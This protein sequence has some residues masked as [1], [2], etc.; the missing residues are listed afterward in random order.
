MGPE[1]MGNGQAPERMDWG[2]TTHWSVVLAAGQKENPQ[3]AEALERLCKIYWYPLYAY[4]RRKGHD[5]P[6]AQ[7][8]IQDFFASLL[9]KG[10]LE[11]VDPKKGRFRS[12]LICAM[13]HFLANHWRRAAAAKRGG[14]RPL[15]SLDDTAEKR[16]AAEAATDLTPEKLYERRWALS[17]LERALHRL[18]QEYATTDRG[19]LYDS[20]KQFLSAEPEAGDYER[21]SAQLGISHGAVSTAV[22]RLRQRYQ[23]LVR[24]D[25]AQTVD[26]REEIEDEIRS[27]VAALTD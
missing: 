3:S 22:Y 4:V 17:L 19:T 20:L 15:L 21:V 16:Y 18:H 13:D 12:Y 23:A 26:R 14:G 9:Q 1:G 5:V 2:G 11:K 7:D 6:E 8:L 24:E 25:V 10:W 27:L